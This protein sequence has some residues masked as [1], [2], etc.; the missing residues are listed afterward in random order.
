MSAD[1]Q[2]IERLQDKLRE[3]DEVVAE[4]AA[5]MVCLK[6]ELGENSL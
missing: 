6:K 4:I 5:E 1:P 3:K 2:L